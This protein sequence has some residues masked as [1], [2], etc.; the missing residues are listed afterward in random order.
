MIGSYLHG[1]MLPKNPAVADFLISTALERRFGEPLSPEAV[2]E[3]I[4]D[5]LTEQARTTAAKR[6]R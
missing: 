2:T 5:A 1:S 4:D 3:R 6:P